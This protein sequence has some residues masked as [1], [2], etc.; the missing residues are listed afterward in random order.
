MEHTFGPQPPQVLQKKMG[1][2]HS[3]EECGLDFSYLPKLYWLLKCPVLRA[4]RDERILELINNAFKKEIVL[5]FYGADVYILV[6]R[7]GR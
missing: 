7:R 5:W 1:R 3:Y 2:W 4:I 6:R